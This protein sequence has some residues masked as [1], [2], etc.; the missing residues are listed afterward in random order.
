MCVTPACCSRPNIIAP[1]FIFQ[2]AVRRSIRSPWQL[3][4]TWA[5]EGNNCSSYLMCFCASSAFVPF[6]ES[7]GGKNRDRV[8]GKCVCVCVCIVWLYGSVYA[9]PS[10]VWWCGA[11]VKG[12][13]L[14]ISQNSQK[15]NTRQ[16]FL[17]YSRITAKKS[18]LMHWKKKEVP[19]TK[20]SLGELTNILHLERMRCH[21]LTK[22]GP[23][24][25]CPCY[26][27]K[28]HNKTRFSTYLYGYMWITLHVLMP[29][30]SE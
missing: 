15:T 2:E 11:L 13:S 3:I 20:M 27:R 29:V 23:L 25:L 21:I 5:A 18:L 9:D 16:R 1:V 28:K 26:V 10:N 17:S 19:C 8:V 14:P 22:L 24:S 12:Q 7:K 4:V 6:N 30:C